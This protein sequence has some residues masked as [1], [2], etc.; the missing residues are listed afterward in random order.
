M[1][2]FMRV[3]L[4]SICLLSLL[5]PVDAADNFPDF[6]VRKARDYAITMENA[7]VVIGV[8]AVDDPKDQ[9]TYFD[10]NLT[11]RGFA[12]IFIVVQNDSSGDSFLL[13]KEDIRY[14]EARSMAS[15]P[16]ASMQAGKTAAVDSL[17][18][19][20]LAGLVVANLLFIKSE[21]IQQNILRKELR[22]QTLSPGTSM[23]GFIYVPVRKKRPRE[24][25]RV[26]IR[27]TRAGREEP[28]VLDLVF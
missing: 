21:H 24:K 10:T 20:G 27:V 6:P 5:V 15:E 22:S 1:K 3:T 18:L 28:V 13:D 4:T 17:A 12:P 23:H 14:G 25:I 19:V 7:C 26:Q 11:A 9:K 8:Q 2:V 16:N